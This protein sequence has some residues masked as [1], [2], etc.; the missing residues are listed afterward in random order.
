[1]RSRPSSWTM[2]APLTMGHPNGELTEAGMGR[3]GKVHWA[4]PYFEAPALREHA[5]AVRKAKSAAAA[6]S[7][8][9]PSPRM[10][11][12]HCHGSVGCLAAGH[13]RAHLRKMGVIAA[14]SRNRWLV[15]SQV[16]TAHRRHLWRARCS[17]RVDRQACRR[18]CAQALAQRIPTPRRARSR[19]V[20][21]LAPRLVAYSVFAS[22]DHQT[23]ESQARTAGSKTPS[24]NCLSW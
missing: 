10:S 5:A 23:L 4:V 22:F 21:H 9:G 13:W 11:S 20:R 8:G 15:V 7:L 1:M 14:H 18:S 6:Q 24:L 3:T 16:S 17:P 2:R 12:S 19:V